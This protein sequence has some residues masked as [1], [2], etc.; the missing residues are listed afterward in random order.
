MPDEASPLWPILR[1]AL[2]KRCPKCGQAP[3]F[4]TYLKQVDTCANCGEAFGHIRADDAPAWLTIIVMGHVLAFTLM[5]I[6]PSTNWPMWV[7]ILVWQSFAIG[8]VFWLLP[9]AKAIFI[10]IIW[11]TGANGE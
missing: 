9:R 4:R 6:A 10:A 11:R 7:N 3:L 1:A 8:M 2:S 5:F